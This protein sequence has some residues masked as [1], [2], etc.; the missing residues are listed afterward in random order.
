M[1]TADVGEYSVTNV[2]RKSGPLAYADEENHCIS[3]FKRYIGS[4]RHFDW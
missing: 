2:V 3:N 4:V 1:G